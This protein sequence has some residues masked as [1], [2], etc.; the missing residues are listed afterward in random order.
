MKKISLFIVIYSVLSLFYIFEKVG[1]QG[2][3][4]LSVSLLRFLLFNMKKDKREHYLSQS[5][6]KNC[7]KLWIQSFLKKLTLSFATHVGNSLT[8]NMSFVISVE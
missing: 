6:N 8:L 7:E 4:H 3:A 2:K 1:M 5:S